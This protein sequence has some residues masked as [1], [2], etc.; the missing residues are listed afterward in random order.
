[1]F[2]L[3]LFRKV[4][5]AWSTRLFYAVVVTGYVWRFLFGTISGIFLVAILFYALMWIASDSKPLTPS[6]LLIWVADLPTEF[7][8]AIGASLLTIVGFLIAFHTATM[9]WQHQANA[10]LKALV[11]GEIEQF[12]GEAS[13]LLTQAEI[14][15][16]SVVDGVNSIQ[17]Q[18]ATPETLFK[19]QYVADR[20]PAFVAIRQRLSEMSIDVHRILG[21]NYSLLS[22]VWDAT[23]AL[24]EVNAAFSE[25][26]Q[27]MWFRLP[28]VTKDDPQLIVKFLG[29]VSVTECLS[30]ISSYEKNFDYINGVTG[31]IRGSLLAPIV[32]FSLSSLV[33]L[34]TNRTQFREAI[35]VL[36]RNQRPGG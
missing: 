7:R 24:R 35:E 17:G 12:F 3:S 32:G 30:F 6:Q 21:T 14:Y 1:M 34:L 22:T 20:T 13:R 2:G 16:R 29:Q 15:A 27:T 11:A 19:I 5:P 23:T 10:H 26:T 33:G 9:N 8:I 4:S 18:P 25:V 36:H 31:G 28:Y